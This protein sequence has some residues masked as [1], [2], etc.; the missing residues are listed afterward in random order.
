MVNALRS[1]AF[2]SALHTLSGCAARPP[3]PTGP[4][5]ATVAA[6]LSAADQLV[7]AGCLDCLTEAY[8]EYEA[9]RPVES[10]VV[11]A[12]RTAALISI[13]ER[14][15]GIEDSGALAGARALALSSPDLFTALS[16]LLDIA[17]TLSGSGP[18]G[19][20]RGDAEMAASALA[21]RNRVAWTEMLRGRADDDALSAYLWMSFNCTYNSRSSAE[22]DA[23]LDAVPSWR[24]TP[25]VRYRLATCVGIRDAELERLFE[26]DGRFTEITYFK[27]LQKLLSGDL[28]A[29]DAEFER[30]YAWRPRWA[31]VA[32]TRANLF[33]TA[34]EFERAAD[35]YDRALAI[36]PGYVEA[37]LGRL[38]ALT[39]AG[40][41]EEAV[42]AADALLALERWF[43]GDARYL[44]ALN[45]TV[46]NRI[47]EAWDDVEGAA[48]LI[49]NAD[50]PKLAGVIA[51]RR[52]QLAVAREKFEE[53]HSRQTSDCEIPFY[54][55]TVVAEQRE[56]SRTVDVL[57]EA[58]ACFDASEDAIRQDIVR[59]RA[60]N[61]A[62]DR[63]M[64]QIGR[65]EQQLAAQ[66]RMR[67]TSWFNVA[68]ASF[69]L[70][71]Y[72]QA[73]EYAER[74]ADDA[75]FRER[76]LDLLS[77]LPAAR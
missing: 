72:P 12:G 51:V 52:Q 42:A 2:L 49:T 56:W 14:E 26:A 28:D 48:K 71:H 7:R 61:A 36:R 18:G 24:V 20:I 34:E 13:R 30:A 21:A 53:A 27:G 67:I 63:Q 23:L 35:F 50:V 3:S 9:L 38:R 19:Q 74:V 17:E 11:A 59:I 65:R 57:T 37:M 69:N 8:L 22:A 25:L 32:N 45:E 6:R 40:R 10:A 15:L 73:T 33:V 77:R 4:D 16:P 54:L 64:R 75:Q 44:R 76:A 39:Y 5:P 31:A 62:P 43:V 29:A 60:S 66:A 55:G 46:L 58:I 68:A 70:G 1:L 47:D 41:S